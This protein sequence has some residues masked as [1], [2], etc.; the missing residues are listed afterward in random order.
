MEH[1]I[2]IEEHVSQ[3]MAHVYILG[4]LSEAERVHIG[5]EIAHLCKENNI[6]KVI[7]DVREA[8]LGYSLIRS[9]QAILT[10]SDLGML[11][12][13]YGAV[14]YFHN[15]EQFEHAKTVAVNRGIH[16]VGF[17]QNIDE[18]IEWLAGKS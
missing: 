6:N 10:L 9:H 16:N 15:K 8:K 1:R 2:E 12:S 14:I 13:D 4:T 17:F 5:T 7:F 11:K 18:G 3:R